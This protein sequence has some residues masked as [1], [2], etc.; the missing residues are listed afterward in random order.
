MRF[1]TMHS[2]GSRPVRRAVIALGALTTVGSASAAAQAVPADFAQVL[3]SEVQWKP[4][5]TVAGAEMA[6]L[7]GDPAG[8]GPYAIRI[9]FAPNTRVAPHTHPEARTYT[10]LAG[11]WKLG[12][13][14]R[15]DAAALRTY[16]TGSLYRLPAATPHFQESGAGVTVIQIQARGPTKTEL[17]KPE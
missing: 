10:V 13:G 16:P 7:L 5:P 14:S 12:F 2:L 6:I 4:H 11:E 15:F 1:V 8:E 17:I 3:P 9:R